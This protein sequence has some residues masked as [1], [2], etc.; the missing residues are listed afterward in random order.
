MTEFVSI[1]GTESESLNIPQYT[2]ESIEQE[3][4]IEVEELPTYE[5]TEPE[6][7]PELGGGLN[8]R[9]K[10]VSASVAAVVARRRKSHFI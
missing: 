10:D 8:P 5:T 7:E 4:K 6:P 1:E 9:G 2:T 3:T